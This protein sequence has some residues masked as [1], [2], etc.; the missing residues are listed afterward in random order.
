MLKNA[1]VLYDLPESNSGNSAMTCAIPFYQMIVHGSVPYCG[2]VPGN[3][4]SDYQTE[5]LKWIEYGSE[6]YFVL[7]YE[8][9]D[10][11]KNTY[12]TDAY[13]TDYEQWIEAA[14]ECA[15]EF[16]GKLAF[17]ADSVM[18]SHEYLSDDLVRVKYDNGSSIIINYSS[19]EQTADG[20]DVPAEDYVVIGGEN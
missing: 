17:T 13:A 12:V 8:S 20:V 18:V 6:P 19:E 2:T 3:M 14:A 15:D 5:K 16:S 4:A 10:L 1:S 11:M 9:S 7:T